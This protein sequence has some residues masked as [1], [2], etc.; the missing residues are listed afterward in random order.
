MRFAWPPCVGMVTGRRIAIS[1]FKHCHTP[2]DRDE[3]GVSG[4]RE[5]R[6]S[7][8]RAEE[9]DQI[10]DEEA[11]D[12]RR[13]TLWAAC[14]PAR[15]HGGDSRSGRRNRK[16]VHSAKGDISVPRHAAHPSVV[17][18]RSLQ[19]TSLLTDTAEHI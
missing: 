14:Q 6:E 16:K 12:E 10:A 19:K 11:R 3:Y 2:S 1:F 8:C 7:E 4:L 15:N 9:P 13:G 17:V 18:L 5:R